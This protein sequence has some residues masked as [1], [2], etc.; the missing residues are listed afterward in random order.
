MTCALRLVQRIVRDSRRDEGAVVVIAGPVAVEADFPRCGTSEGCAWIGEDAR[1]SWERNHLVPFWGEVRLCPRLQDPLVEYFVPSF[2]V[3][4]LHLA[5]YLFHAVGS[6]EVRVA[7]VGLVNVDLLELA[8]RVV[9][10]AEILH[11]REDFDHGCEAEDGCLF[12]VEIYEAFAEARPVG[13]IVASGVEVFFVTGGAILRR[14]VWL[15]SV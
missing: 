9:A 13:Q 11:L 7:F 3:R 6:H 5:A 2:R 10:S 12:G 15:V 4:F 8:L 1:T 14:C